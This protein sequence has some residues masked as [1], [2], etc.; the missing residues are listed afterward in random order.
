MAVKPK[1]EIANMKIVLVRSPSYLS[2][3]LRKIFGIK[4]EKKNRKR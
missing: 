4:K 2:P 1:K 3:I